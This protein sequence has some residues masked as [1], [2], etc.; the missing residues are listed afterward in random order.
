[1]YINQ[2]LYR[3]FCPYSAEFKEAIQNYQTLSFLNKITVIAIST[4]A[5]L[6]S[7]FIGG[8]LAFPVFIRIVTA[9]SQH[10]GQLEEYEDIELD[11]KGFGN[12][13]RA[14]DHEEFNRLQP[15]TT[16]GWAELHMQQEE[17]L[18]LDY[19]HY[20]S[21]PEWCLESLPYRN[22]S[23]AIRKKI[24]TNPNDLI[25]FIRSAN[26]DQLVALS[27]FFVKGE[28]N[29]QQLESDLD[30]E[31]SRLHFESF[32]ENANRGVLDTWISRV[33]EVIR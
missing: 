20:M 11:C 9:Y 26:L 18:L 6:A 28:K 25:R 8:L 7:F 13:A 12:N 23:A 2:L 17:N 14:I 5:A 16:V 3:N 10:K 19:Y 1:M 27:T 31:Q 24:G 22:V 33:G 15:L 4:L 30:K 29:Y 21:Q 32:V